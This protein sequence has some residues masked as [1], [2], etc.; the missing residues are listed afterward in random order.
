MSGCVLWVGAS[1]GLSARIL[2]AL[3]GVSV[4]RPGADG[5]AGAR[6]AVVVH[7]PPAHD[8]LGWTA[9]RTEPRV[10]VVL[11]S[12]EPSLDEAARAVALGVE[13]YLG[14]ETEPRALLAAVERARSRREALRGETLGALA[15]P[16][17]DAVLGHG[18][19]I[20]K[21]FGAVARAAASGAP[22]L[23][24]GETGVGK[25]W[26][27]RAIHRYSAR[28]TGPFVAVNCS[29]LPEGTLESELFGHAR[30]GFT[31][32]LGARKG[33]F[34]TAHGGT[35]FLDEMGELSHRV[36]AELLRVLQEG[37]VRPVGSDEALTVDVRVLC[38]THRDVDAQVSS[39]RLREDLLFR[40]RVL[41]LEVPPLRARREDIPLL[42]RHFLALA[43]GPVPPSQRA[44]AP[45]TLA[46]LQRRA[47]PGNVRE[48]QAVIAR[49]AA[50]S[51]GAVLLPED[52]EEPAEGP[53]GSLEDHLDALWA[54][55][56]PGGV[57]TLAAVQ[58]SLLRA[59]TRHLGGNKSQ[60]AL[61]LG[62]DRK[63]LR[64]ALDPDEE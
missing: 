35:V 46:A 7:E 14:P 9:A 13:A 54:Q 61:R 34:Q 42:A 47:W 20:V 45:E 58:R 11:V 56:L 43:P 17:R 2:G 37:E 27:A 30:G 36:Q 63:T 22:V 49:A 23:I 33:L 57:P 55:L 29:A 31:G 53:P 25:E 59:V 60:A 16:V 1:G 62:I 48:L 18:P 24:R 15:A 32:A 64:R 10:P 8:G 26:V 39:G 4:V 41:D 21:L 50:L 52:L 12:A 44:L 3:E 19:A 51:P 5:A 40:L 28:G 38:A 6:C